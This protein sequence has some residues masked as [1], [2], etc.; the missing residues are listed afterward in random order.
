MG[1]RVTF[2]WLISPRKQGEHVLKTRAASAWKEENI[3]GEGT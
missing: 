1:E 2:S 3:E